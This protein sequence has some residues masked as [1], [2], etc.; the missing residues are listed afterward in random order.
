MSNFS[1]IPSQ[2]DDLVKDHPVVFISYSWDSEDHKSWVRKLSDDLRTK[3]AVNTLLDQYN[4]GGYDL[5]QFMNKGIE[6][7]DRVILIGTPAYKEKSEK[8][9]GGAKY[10]DQLISAE[11]YHK[12]GSSK[13]IPVLRIGKFDTSFRS[14][15]ETRT[16]YDMRED[17]QYETNLHILAAELWNNPLNAAPALGPKP[18]FTLAST[19]IPSQKS[20]KE[21]SCDQFVEEVKRLLSTP[22]SEIAYTE[23]IE[24]E[25]KRAYETIQV[26]S[27]YHFSI[28]PELFS[29]YQ[30][31]HFKAVEKLMAASIIVV[32]YGDLK[33]QQLF[34]DAVLKLCMKPFVNGEIT[35]EGTNYLHLLAATFLLYTI[36]VACIK[37]SYFQL[38]NLIFKTKVPAGNVFSPSYG[39]SLAFLAGTCHWRADVLNIYMGS[40]WIYPFSELL[41]RKLY[42]LFKEYTIDM[43][44]FRCIYCAWEH[45]FSLLY[46]HYQCGL[47]HQN[48]FT[49]GLFVLKRVEF[50]RMQDN[51]YTL[52]YNAAKERKDQWEPLK[53]G[54]FEG[55][56]TVF[57]QT[58]NEG[59]EYYKKY[60]RWR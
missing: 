3:Y 16:G 26:N 53:Q 13:F 42:P 38:L 28:T 56:Y 57:E 47:M 52:F 58:Y 59:E 7:A 29:Q 19:I 46:H 24:G 9:D 35:T 15:I 34:V 51:F 10:E 45:L 32:R 31:I 30:E 43:E 18:E 8:Y 40:T 20:L 39:F 22:H 17:A 2:F 44:D 5:I 27:N 21:L 11:L 36:G 37:F 50:F 33:Q 41:W 25:T 12:M 60:G 55:K 23:L 14:L 1:D 6:I 49:T 54:L 48:D 4:R